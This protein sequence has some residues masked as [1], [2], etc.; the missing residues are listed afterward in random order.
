MLTKDFYELSEWHDRS[1]TSHWTVF[2][3]SDP[4]T[5]EGLLLGFRQE[6]CEEAEFHVKL[7]FIAPDRMYSVRDDDSGRD[8]VIDGATLSNGLSLRL[9]EPRS[10]LL[11][12]I[13]P[14]N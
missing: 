6:S 13:V 2:A 8:W 10:S 4:E 1:D 11:W 5:G 9:D 12:H 3:Y 14:L 7:P